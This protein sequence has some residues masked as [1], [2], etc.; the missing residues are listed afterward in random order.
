MIKIKRWK[1]TV[2]QEGSNRAGPNRAYISRTRGLRQIWARWAS[3][4]RTPRISVVIPTLNEEENLP[5]V[6]PAIPQDVYEI[7]LVDG[8]S[9]D[10]TVEVARQLRPDVRV[11][12]Q[13][14]RGKGDALRAGFAAAGGEIIVM[15]DADGSTDPSE[16]PAYVGALLSGADFAKGSR[17]AQ[18]GGTSDM[19]FY[20]RLGNWVFVRMVRAFFG[21]N[22]SD[23]CYGYNAIW[24][25]LVPYL[26]LDCDGFEIETMLNVRVLRAG[27][28]VV[29]VPSFE[30]KRVYGEG[31]LRTLPDGWRVLKTITKEVMNHWPRP[32]I[33]PPDFLQPRKFLEDNQ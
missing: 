22:Y 21:G 30:Y 4:T 27:L 24:R 13:R 14:G 15:M 16:I 2:T 5:H 10:R 31:R 8:H 33:Q 19:P 26:N 23:L 1:H 12:Q 11:I 17:F 7:V 20:R 28:K 25:H 18:G 6:L 3:A 9:T 29:E 32:E